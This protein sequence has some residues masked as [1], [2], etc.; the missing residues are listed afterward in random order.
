MSYKIK[1]QPNKVESRFAPFMLAM[2]ILGFIGVGYTV[3]I[4]LFVPFFFAL[5]FGMMG[6]WMAKVLY[7]RSNIFLLFEE[8]A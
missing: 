2:G 7:D 6:I 8:G 4:K 3:S 1:H 5:F